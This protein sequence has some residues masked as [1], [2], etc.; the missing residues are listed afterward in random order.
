MN[1]ETEKPVIRTNPQPYIIV[2]CVSE[3]IISQQD[4]GNVILQISA[5]GCFYTE[6]LP[7]GESNKAIPDN[8]FKKSTI[9]NLPLRNAGHVKVANAEQNMQ[10]NCINNYFQSS[11]IVS[12]TGVK[13]NTTPKKSYKS[14]MNYGDEEECMDNN[15]QEKVS[16]VIKDDDSQWEKINS[17]NLVGGDTDMQADEIQ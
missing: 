13:G 15:D 6:S 12:S 1:G 11:G 16:F 17:E 10:A 7:T 4:F 5:L 3:R 2:D 8:L 14:A 9:A